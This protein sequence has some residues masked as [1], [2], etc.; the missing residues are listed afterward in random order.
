M[1]KIEYKYNPDTLNYEKV[2]LGF[3]HYSLKV[4]KYSFSGLLIAG[5]LVVLVYPFIKEYAVSN[6]ERE[7]SNL[8]LQISEFSS[9]LD[10]LEQVIAHIQETDDNI[11]RTI[12][13]AEPFPSYKRQRGTGGNPN[14]YKTLE[15]YSHSDQVISMSKRIEK[16][17]KKS[18]AQIQSYKELVELAKNKQKMLSS[19]PAILPISDEE[20]TRVSS[21]FGYRIDPIYKTRKMHAGMDFTAPTGSLIHS[22]GDGVVEKADYST[23]GYGQHVII[24]HGY[25]Y[26]SHYAHMSKTLVKVGQKVK[27]GE[28]IG[29]VGNTG[30]STAPHLHYEIIKNGTKIDPINFYF[31]DLSPEEYEKVIEL[32]NSSNQSFD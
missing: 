15:G 24:N 12:F 22:S 27:R 30:K 18:V 20:L 1:A 5:M 2:T 6:I 4:L 8:K 9:E 17:E 11:Y 7:N 23:G 10:T 25:G 31:N 29:H 19:I 32:S 28:V 14:K 13:E 21:G 3:K 26:K 16:L